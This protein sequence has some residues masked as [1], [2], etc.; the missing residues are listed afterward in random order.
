MCPG[1]AGRLTSAEPAGA[2]GE[3]QADKAL[4]IHQ[5]VYL[6]AL[7]MQ[8]AH[9]PLSQQELREQAKRAKH[10]GSIKLCS[11]EP[12]MCPGHAGSPRSAEPAGAEGEHDNSQAGLQRTLVP[13]KKT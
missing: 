9:V 12:I 10:L 8:V 6:R 5:V 11:S 13:I 4:R 2:D 7:V 3:R 1:R